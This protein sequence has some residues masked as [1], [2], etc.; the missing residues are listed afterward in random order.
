[1]GDR[2][3]TA[4][5]VSG[6]Q[7]AVAALVSGLSSGAALAGRGNWLWILMWSIPMAAAAQLILRRVGERKM[8]TWLRTLFRVWAVVP[9]ARILERAATRLELT[10]G[11]SPKLWLLVLTAAPLLWMCWGKPAPFFR[12]V[13]ILWLAMAAVLALVLIFGAARV[14]WQ[15]L[16]PT[17]ETVLPS[18]LL[19]GESVTPALFL[20]PY[21]YNVREQSGRQASLWLAGLGGAA[22]GLSLVTVGLLGGV[23]TGVSQPFFVAAGL[24][25]RSARCEG[26]LSVLWLLPDLTAAGLICRV[27]GDRRWPALGL[28]F[29]A[30]LALTGIPGKISGGTVVLAS[31]FLL[32]MALIFPGK[33]EK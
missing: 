16:A 25:G 11:G 17:A 30:A 31:I 18:A 23:S 3:L 5:D 15:W 32:A 28:A 1:M 2:R 22:A 12:T 26:L 29:A 20:L 33:K 8:G 14:E 19:V 13:E 6:R 9:A 10:S 27:W 7:A 24:L 4:E 21:I